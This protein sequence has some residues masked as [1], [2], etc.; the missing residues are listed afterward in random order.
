MD[1]EHKVLVIAPAADHD[2]T[3]RAIVTLQAAGLEHEIVKVIILGEVRPALNDKSN[4]LSGT[5]IAGICGYLKSRCCRS[6]ELTVKLKPRYF[7][8]LLLITIHHLQEYVFGEGKLDDYLQESTKQ[9]HYPYIFI[10]K[11]FVGDHRYE[12]VF[13]AML[14]IP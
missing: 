1:G 10:N 14:V 9:T 4:K 11:E 12:G 3:N 5:D 8:I 2:S 7:V 13:R 6:R